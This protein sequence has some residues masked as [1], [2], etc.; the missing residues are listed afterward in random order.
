MKSPNVG[1]LK[2]NVLQSAHYHLMFGG[3]KYGKNDDSYIGLILLVKNKLGRCNQGFLSCSDYQLVKTT[4]WCWRFC[5]ILSG[6]ILPSDSLVGVICYT[7]TLC[8]ISLFS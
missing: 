7:F 2:E 5:L 1:A 6:Q 8:F 4:S 3:M